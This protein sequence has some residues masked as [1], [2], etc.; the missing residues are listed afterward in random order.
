MFGGV[1][2]K[3][4]QV[5]SALTSSPSSRFVRT[6]CPLFDRAAQLLFL[7]QMNA[8]PVVCCLAFDNFRFF[9]LF[10]STRAVFWAAFGRKVIILSF[11]G[12]SREPSKKQRFFTYVQEANTLKN[13][14]QQIVFH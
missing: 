6:P 12:A 5:S 9:V 11:Q 14:E 10:S 3:L 1:Y 4:T 13:I 8:L 7:D 2:A